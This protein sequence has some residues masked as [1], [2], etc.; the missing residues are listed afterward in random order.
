MQASI[1]LVLP[2]PFFDLEAIPIRV[3]VLCSV[4]PLWETG[5]DLATGE[6]RLHRF[7]FE[8]PAGFVPAPA[9]RAHQ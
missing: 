6:A 8:E 2:F 5:V 7:R 3:L 9:G 1:G 4:R